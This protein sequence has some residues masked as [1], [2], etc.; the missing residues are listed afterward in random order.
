VSIYHD[1]LRRRL[2]TG[3]LQETA[4]WF[5]NVCAADKLEW[6]DMS[7]LEVRFL[8]YIHEHYEKWLPRRWMVGARNGPTRILKMRGQA[9]VGR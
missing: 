4:M 6:K 8:N 9:R 5:I 7:P 3:K 1:E 2:M